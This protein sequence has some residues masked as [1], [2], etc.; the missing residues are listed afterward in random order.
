MESRS[1][2][3]TIK[4]KLLLMRGVMTSRRAMGVDENFKAI[5]S[6]NNNDEKRENSP[7]WEL[8]SF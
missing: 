3:E 2:R 1:R 4:N 7:S 5:E 8:G 6:N